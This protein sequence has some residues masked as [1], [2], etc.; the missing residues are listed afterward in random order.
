MGLLS[1]PV[2]IAIVLVVLAT[3][4]V[5]YVSAIDQREQTATAPPA[6]TNTAMP[7][8]E[9]SEYASTNIDSR[10]ATEHRPAS[11]YSHPLSVDTGV[12]QQLTDAP[13]PSGTNGFAGGAPRTE[14]GL[15][16]VA[17]AADMSGGGSIAA[18]RR[19]PSGGPSRIDSGLSGPDGT[20]PAMGAG[21]PELEISQPA[22]STEM[23]ISLGPGPS[24]TDLRLPG[25]GEGEK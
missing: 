1:R 22:A 10:G 13:D 8:T 9:P 6:A 25:P 19:P 5:L 15:D 18:M 16:P 2:S 20:Q 21:I 11:S 3:V 12:T 23:P 14:R 4:I 7:A 24:Q 17:V